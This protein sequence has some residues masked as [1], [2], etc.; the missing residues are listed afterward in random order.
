MSCASGRASSIRAASPSIC[1]ITADEIESLAH[2]YCDDHAPALI[3]AN[4]GLQRVRGGGMAMRNIACLPAL[5]GAFRDAA[6]G[7]LLSTCGNFT[8]RRSRR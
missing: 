1:G 2:L 5:V 3:R 4:Y 6:G 7:I 8:H